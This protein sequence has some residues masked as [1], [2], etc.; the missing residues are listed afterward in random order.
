MEEYCPMLDEPYEPIEV[1]P[2]V[3]EEADTR[4]ELISEDY[5]IASNMAL[6][7]DPFPDR[8]YL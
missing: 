5:P 1:E 6:A 2:E 3:L 8:Y 4:R 7:S